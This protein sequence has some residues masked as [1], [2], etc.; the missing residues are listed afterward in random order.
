M[1]FTSFDFLI[2]FVLVWIIQRL[3]PHRPRNL[4]LLVASCFFYAC[5]DW[6]FL[7]LMWV[8]ICTDYTVSRRIDKSQSEVRRRCLMVTSCVI[9]LSILGFFKYANFFA[10]SLSALLGQFGF[11]SGP[12][13]LNILLPVGIS[14]Y[15]FQSMSYTIDVYRRQMPPLK[16][17]LDY[18]L[19]VTIFPHMVAGPI[20]R[21]AYM[22]PQILRKT[23]PSYDDFREGSW[24]I[25]KGVFKKTVMA[26]NL[27]VIVDRIFSA[28]SPTGPEVLLGTYAFAFQIYG[29]F[30]GY[31]DIARGV[32]RYLGYDFML[33]FRRPYLATDPSDFWQRWHIS[34]S[35]WL[36]DYLYIPLG[37][38]RGSTFTTCRNLLITMLLGGLWHGAAWKYV[39]WGAFHGLMLLLFRLL[40]CRV[41]PVC[42]TLKWC[43]QVFGMFHLTCLG[44]LIFRVDSVAQLLSMLSALTGGWHASVSVGQSAWAL[45]VLALPV[46]TVQML[47]EYSG[48]ESLVQKIS[49][50]PRTVVFLTLTLAILTLGSFGGREFIYFQF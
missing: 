44:W 50:V 3:L 10:D 46:I 42:G 41:A 7:G 29:D 31:S 35:S 22:A 12:F 13:T 49:L 48:E 47:E 20:N 38:N 43:L 40:N 16:N 1:L 4:F 23:L 14:F 21:G 2:F 8:T 17:L 5:W 36:R 26:D 27:A 9:N 33:N 28:A 34:L 18:A 6:R 19:F 45:L 37:G 15:T 11:Q 25:L 30:A 39:I 24:L 32:G